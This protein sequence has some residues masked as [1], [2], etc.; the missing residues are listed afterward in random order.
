[1]DYEYRQ[2]NNLHYLTNL[3][4]KGATL[5]LMPGNTQTPEILFMPRRN[6]FS[7]IWN[8]RM[9][10]AEDAAHASG[11]KEIYDAREFELFLQALRTRQPYRPKPEN[12]L[13]TSLSS[14]PQDG[15]LNGYETLFSAVE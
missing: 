12:V 14:T 1:A 3:K 11:V 6:A 4:Q 9:Y 10:S 2:E 13:L 7:E 15:T 8:G 5:I